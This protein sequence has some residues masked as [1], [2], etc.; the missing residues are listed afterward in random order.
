MNKKIQVG[1]VF[2]SNKYGDFKIIENVLN[3]NLKLNFY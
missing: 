3:I 2:S 1:D